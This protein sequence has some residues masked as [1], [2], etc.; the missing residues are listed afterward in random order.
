MATDRSVSRSQAG[1]VLVVALLLL[2]CGGG[3]KQDAGVDADAGSCSE[4]AQAA[5]AKRF[6]GTCFALDAGSSPDVTFRLRNAS[7]AEVWVPQHKWFGTHLKSELCPENLV[8]LAPDASVDLPPWHPLGEVS[9]GCG[10]W[11]VPLPPGSY[12][13]QFKY[14]LDGG[15]FFT[16]FNTSAPYPFSL[17]AESDVIEVELP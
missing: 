7:S 12:Q 14:S 2:G 5:A 10:N 4:Q 6:S 13:V 8:R 1:V 15:D 11:Y 3:S 17:T 9:T 16:N